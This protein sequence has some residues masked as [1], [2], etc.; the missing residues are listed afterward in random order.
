MR[1]ARHCVRAV[2][3]L[4]ALMPDSGEDTLSARGQMP[5]VSTAATR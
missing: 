1:D 4:Q 5:F 3:Y 2:G